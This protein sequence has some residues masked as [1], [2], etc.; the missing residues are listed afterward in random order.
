VEA[1]EIVARYMIVSAK[2]YDGAVRIA[3]E[4][5]AGQSG[6]GSLEIRGRHTERSAVLADLHRRAGHEEPACR[7]REL[8]L[9]A[10]P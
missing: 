9:A 1:K 4:G 7:Y 6:G 8:A 10:A 3:V 5:P 2:D